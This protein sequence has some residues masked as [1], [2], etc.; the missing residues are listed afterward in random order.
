MSAG[1]KSVLRETPVEQ[2]GK[3]SLLAPG[4]DG[5]LLRTFLL[6][7]CVKVL[8][9][10]TYH[11]TD[12]EVHRNWLAITHSL[13]L[14]EWYV[15]SL[16]PWTLD[17]PPLFAWF[18][19]CLSQV[20]V[21]FD[22]EM[23]RVENLNYASLATIY[24][25][26]GTVIFTDVVLAYGAREASRTF[27]KSASSCAAFIF[28]SLCNA[29]LL[30]VD[31]IHFQYNGFLLGVLLI[32][33]ANVSRIGEQT[34]VL[35]GAAWFAVLLNLKHLYLY[36]APAYTIWLLK[37]YCLNS[38]KF[39]RRLFTLGFIVLTILAVSF[40]P[41]SAQLPQVISR[42]FPFK[43]GLVHSYWA[44]N[45]WALYIAVEKILSVIWKNLGW[46]RDAKSAVMTG[47]LVQEQSFLI[48]PTP[49]PVVTFLLIFVAMVPALWCLLF[50]KAYM[51]SKCFVRCVI[52]CALS[53]FMLGWHVHEKAILTAIIPLCILAVTDAGDARIFIIL[54]NA[55]Y[56]ALLPLLYPA[57]LFLLKLLLSLAHVLSSILV[58]TNQH[59]EPLLRLH[60]KLYLIPLPLITIYEVVLHKSLFGEKLPFLPLAFT[61]VYCAIG[62][63]YC[64]LSYYYMYLRHSNDVEAAESKLKRRSKDKLS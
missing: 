37:S 56:T 25:Q 9:I 10:P 40:G 35:R 24:F 4:V 2:G 6:I 26:R 3:A 23:V 47:G 63:T 27:C 22:P 38:N 31:H 13:P 18:E 30:I 39:F 5:T 7:T 61:S 48:L 16:S 1:E 11:S 14:R 50:K 20:A 58:L 36:V 8:L 45:A 15:N 51:N 44:A 19:Y 41:F 21:L 55:G 49:T 43:R 34:S 12:F 32:S 42:L 33:L 53:S 29:G 59:G 52:I 54:S 57:N 60:E 62:I 64:W 17:Y 28:L 46:L